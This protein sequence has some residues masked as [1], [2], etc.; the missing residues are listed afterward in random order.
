MKAQF[1]WL[2]AY[3]IN[4]I[5]KIQASNGN[6]SAGWTFNEIE[7]T[8]HSS[9]LCE[10]IFLDCGLIGFSFSYMT[11]SEV[12]VVNIEVMNGFLRQGYG[13]QLLDR[14][15]DRTTKVRSKIY[16]NVSE[17]RLAAQMMLKKSGFICDSFKN[18]VMRFVMRY[19]WI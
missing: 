3:H 2:K 9:A 11:T 13:T 19:E 6:R 17:E 15:I 4:E 18:G 10:G 1:D 5:R 14:L 12:E 16:A 8:I 7:R